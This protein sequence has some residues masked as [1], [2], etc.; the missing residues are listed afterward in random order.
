MKSVAK[1]LRNRK[2]ELILVIPRIKEEKEERS[3]NITIHYVGYLPRNEF[4]RLL[5]R[6]DLYVERCV[7]E[8]L[9][10]ASIE[11]ALLG[12]PIA[13]LTHPRFVDRQDYQ[14][15]VIWSSSFKGLVEA[16]SDYVLHVDHWKPY[17]SKKLREFL[18]T[19]RSWDRLKGSLIRGLRSM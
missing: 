3:N 12:T 1:R 14:E 10:L 5:A 19:R 13:K 18:I 7:D 4:L 15:E 9:G 2:I 17:Y 8:E 11:A 6:S 16:I